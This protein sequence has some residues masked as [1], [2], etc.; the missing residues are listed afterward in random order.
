[1]KPSGWDVDVATAYKAIPSEFKGYMVVQKNQI[2]Q[3]VMA[4]LPIKH[5]CIKV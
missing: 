1:M 2:I 4:L 3:M 5:L